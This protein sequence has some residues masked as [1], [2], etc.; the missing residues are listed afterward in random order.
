MRLALR[1]ALSLDPDVIHNNDHTGVLAWSEFGPKPPGFIT[2]A[3]WPFDQPVT[4]E[5]FRA[6]PGHNVIMVSRAQQSLAQAL[7]YDLSYRGVVHNC[8]AHEN[9]LPHGMTE[10]KERL[11]WIGRFDPM[12]GIEE[13][14]A[15]AR[16]LGKRIVV[17]GK[18]DNYAKP[19]FDDVV[20]PLFAAHGSLIDFRGEV[21]QR[22]ASELMA[23]SEALLMTTR[24]H[25][26]FG[27]VV[28][29][30]LAAGTPVV[31]TDRGAMRELISHGKN[32]FI[33]PMLEGNEIDVRGFVRASMLCENI[34]AEKCRASAQR[35]HPKRM[36]EGYAAVYQRMTQRETVRT[37]RNAIR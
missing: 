23:S 1:A 22:E 17:A 15:I 29:E 30:S 9:F 4:G 2:T 35:F 26:S 11:A 31:A 6:A 7:G 14:I 32:G 21:S 25:E 12:K 18:V 28:A 33:V 10:R 37:R 34:N 20:Q 27:L 8:I 5:A 24:Y 13:A 3:H 36:A 19:Y 16:A